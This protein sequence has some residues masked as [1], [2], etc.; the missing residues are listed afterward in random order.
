MKPHSVEAIDN[1]VAF[2]FLH[3]IFVSFSI[4]SSLKFAY[5]RRTNTHVDL[6]D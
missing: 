1:I 6:I 5:I 4:L 3:L 2:A